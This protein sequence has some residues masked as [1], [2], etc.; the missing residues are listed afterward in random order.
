MKEWSVS[1]SHFTSVHNVIGV[2]CLGVRMCVCI[3]G[4]TF[5]H[6]VLP[7]SLITN[8]AVQVVN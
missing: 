3:Y 2:C 5:K 8:S 6:S 7:T 1:C 4:G